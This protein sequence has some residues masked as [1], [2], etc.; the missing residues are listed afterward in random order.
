MSKNLME[1]AADILSRSKAA[2]P[3]DPLEK[4]K[5]E[6]EDLGGVTPTDPVRREGD[7]SAKNVKKAT[8]PGKPA[9]VGAM[10]MEKVKGEVDVVKE[11]NHDDDHDDDDHDD[12]EH[13]DEH[14]DDEKDEKKKEV[15]EEDEKNGKNGKNGK[16]KDK[17]E[18]EDEDKKKE[19]EEKEEKE[20][21]KEDVKAILS[22]EKNLSENF[23][24][25]IA[26]IY[27]TRVND[28]VQHKVKKIEEK[29]EAKYASELTEAVQ[30]LEAQLVE[31]IDG[32]LNYAV[33]EWMEQN[34]VAIENGIRSELTEEFIAGLRNLF[35]EHY[36]NVPEEKIELVNELVEKVES[37]ETQ[38][39][40][41]VARNIEMKKSLQESKKQ[42]II[43]KVCEGLTRTQTEKIR[44]LV[45]GAE[46]TTDGEFQKTVE[47]IRDNYFPKT[48]KTASAEMLSE[49]ADIS[50][51]PEITDSRMRAYVQA[52]S[53]TL[54]K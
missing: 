41:T 5:G 2:A 53:K 48:T 28:K 30:Q 39:N 32:F 24:S 49:Q 4:V 34:Q 51:Q 7:G 15:N 46:Y 52:I 33:E 40:E 25:K 50:E 26:T 29:L 35:A 23:R 22:S 11:N 19:K 43:N 8:A 21:M 45:E 47:T 1:A 37:L 13:D 12:E 14:D 18:E 54:P 31:K 16:D 38:L 44:S 20:A 10:P 17:D 42:D 3:S 6:V 27:E 36:I 9:S